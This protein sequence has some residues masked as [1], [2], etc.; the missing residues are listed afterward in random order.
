MLSLT[1]TGLY[2]DEEFRFKLYEEEGY[3]KLENKGKYSTFFKTLNE[4][5]DFFREQ[6]SD[7]K[8]VKIGGIFI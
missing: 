7:Y 4:I 3:M 8:K 5:K 2:R 1:I 6:S